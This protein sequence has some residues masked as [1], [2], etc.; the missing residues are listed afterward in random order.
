LRP[1]SLAIEKAAAQPL[2]IW[3]DRQAASLRRRSSE[4]EFDNALKKILTHGERSSGM[5]DP[6]I[7]RF[8]SVLSGSPS[9]ARR[10]ARKI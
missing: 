6:G 7:T 10:C 4:P 5:E 1:A 8:K 2:A 9:P 3:C